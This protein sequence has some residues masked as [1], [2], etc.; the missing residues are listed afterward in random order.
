MLGDDSPPSF[1]YEYPEVE[2]LTTKH[3]LQLEKDSIGLYLSGNL[4]DDYHKDISRHRHTDI[5]TI[6]TAFDENA[7]EYGTLKDRDTV[8]I[9]GIIRKIVRKNTK[10]GGTM[11][12][13]TVEDYLGEIEV[14]VFP[15]LYLKMS[16]ILAIDT[17]VLISG[18]L[19]SR[20]EESVK[21]I[22]QNAL[23][24]I[25][26]QKLSESAPMP[27]SKQIPIPK[28]PEQNRLVTPPS[29]ATPIKQIFIR[30]D[31]F[32][33]EAYR[34]VMALI[35]IFAEQG[36]AEVILYNKETAK[37]QKLT[38]QKLNALPKVIETLYEICGK[39]NIIL[40]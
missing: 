35:S 20:E 5:A 23:P 13:A 17:A 40:R 22:A 7:E 14:I 30:L 34:R 28:K 39:E 8:S 6:L 33:N 27:E 10:N 37:Y 4:L 24:L 2:E 18:T 16:P 11:A 29:N 36:F 31:S 12:F 1:M 21:L 19:S 25:T 32:S 26:N 15:N 9:V 3:L 38:S